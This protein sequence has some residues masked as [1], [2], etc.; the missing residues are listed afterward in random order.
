MMDSCHFPSLDVTVIYVIMTCSIFS[1]FQYDVLASPSGAPDDACATMTPQH[2]G[3]AQ[4]DE[5]PFT[6][7]TL[8]S[9]YTTG[10][11]MTCE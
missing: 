6:I 10:Q 4:E 8:S 11:T 5:P 2:G 7:T 9:N 1:G 3:Y